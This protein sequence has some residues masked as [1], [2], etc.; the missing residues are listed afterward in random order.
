MK[1]TV[2]A[3]TLLLS[4]SGASVRAGAETSIYSFTMNDIDGKPVALENFKGKVLLVVNTASRCGLTPQYEGLQALYEKYRDQGLVILGFPANNF[5][6]QEPGSNEEIKEFCSTKYGVTFPMF[7]KISVLGDDIH[8]LYK[9]L[10]SGAGKAELAGDLTWNFEKFLF[11][12]SGRLTARFAPR[13][14][15]DS[16]EVVRSIEDLLRKE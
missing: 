11:D 4:L 2:F 3:L 7:S 14:K 8:P 13:T 10:T 1:R 5:R 6:G 15:P 12:R 9:Y 16:E